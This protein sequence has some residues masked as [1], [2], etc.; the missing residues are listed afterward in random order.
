MEACNSR[1]E[2]ATSDFLPWWVAKKYHASHA[3]EAQS[4]Q[5][6][7]AELFQ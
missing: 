1:V 4:V 6:Y 7:T 3:G 5:R 2:E